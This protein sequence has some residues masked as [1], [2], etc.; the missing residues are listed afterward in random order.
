MPPLINPNVAATF[1]QLALTAAHGKRHIPF[2]TLEYSI[3]YYCVLS[4][5]FVTGKKDDLS[6]RTN[7]TFVSRG[8]LTP[9]C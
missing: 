8:L 4:G 6:S 9:S 7:V 2:L 3:D 1:H 5:V